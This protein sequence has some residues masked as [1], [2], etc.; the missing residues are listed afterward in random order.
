MKVA[1]LVERLSDLDQDRTIIVDPGGMLEYEID[2][3]I[4]DQDGED[5]FVVISIRRTN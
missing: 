3:V 1:E 5:K 4:Q 2:D